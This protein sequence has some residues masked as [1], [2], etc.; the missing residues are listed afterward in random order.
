MTSTLPRG[1]AT[2]EIDSVRNDIQDILCSGN[3]YCN[4][5]LAR[6][7]TKINNGLNH[8]RLN[9]SLDCMP[10][11]RYHGKINNTS[12]LVDKVSG[13]L[14]E[15]RQKMHGQNVKGK[16]ENE[17][18]EQHQWAMANLKS[19][20]QEMDQHATNARNR[21]SE[22]GDIIGVTDRFT[23]YRNNLLSRPDAFVP[24]W[25]TRSQTT[26]GFPGRESFRGRAVRMSVPL[27]GGTVHDDITFGSV[28]PCSMQYKGYRTIDSLYPRRTVLQRRG[29]PCYS[30]TIDD[31]KTINLMNSQSWSP[32]GG[33]TG[34]GS[35]M[36]NDPTL[37]KTPQEMAGINMV[38]PGKTE[39]MLR[40]NRPL[41]DMPTCDFTVNPKPDYSLYGRTLGKPDPDCPKTTE[42]QVRYE[43]PDGRRL[44]KFPWLRK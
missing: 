23:G 35:L 13:Y 41:T 20:Q 24:N 8:L 1:K 37:A 11:H 6:E 44:V 12:G 40:Y 30:R 4:D 9:E 39:Y 28:R 27:I 43:W 14:Y 10:K 18:R 31:V 17:I 7:M 21:I 5:E 42:Y 3:Y 16:Q 19:I 32:N 15:Y 2:R 36:R 38:F 26:T 34:N 33:G 29:D 22:F 25:T